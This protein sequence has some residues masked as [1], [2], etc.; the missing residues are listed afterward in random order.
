MAH[1]ESAQEH[2]ECNRT[3]KQNL[4]EQKSAQGSSSE[5]V[6]KMF[7]RIA[8]NYVLLNHILSCGL[9]FLWRRKLASIVDNNKKLQILDMATG[10]GDLLIS[11]LKRNHNITNAVGLDISENMLT[12]CRKKIVKHKLY[13]QTTLILADAADTGLF[14]ES[15]DIVTMGF[16]IRNTADAHKTLREIHRLLKK[17]GMVLILEFTLPSNRIFRKLYLLY[18]RNF[19]PTLGRLLSRDKNAYR[20]LNTSIENFYSTEDFSLL[21]QKAGFSNVNVIPLTFGI[22]CIYKAQKVSTGSPEK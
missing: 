4:S 19:V 11:L 8:H 6:C 15:F 1:P 9:D 12:L 13:E 17:D 21:M 22:V 18:L 14:G 10:T 5:A 16:G 20:Y 2:T 3:L 7:D